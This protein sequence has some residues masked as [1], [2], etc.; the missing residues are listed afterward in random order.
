MSL[1]VTIIGND[2]IRSTC[3]NSWKGTD[4]CKDLAAS[5]T[6]CKASIERIVYENWCFEHHQEV[7]DSQIDN[8]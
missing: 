3:T 8:E 1:P 2:R 7:A 5:V 4:K 6:Q